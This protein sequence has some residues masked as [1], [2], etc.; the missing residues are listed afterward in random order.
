MQKLI[1][2]NIEIPLCFIQSISWSKRA[3]TITHNGGYISA[4][5]FE[6]SEISVKMRIDFGTCK[7][8]GLDPAQAFGILDDLKTDRTAMSG[9]FY[10]GG[11]PIYPELEFALTNCN[12]TEIADITGAVSF[13]ECALVFSGVKA[14]KN[15]VREKALELD[16]DTVLP[17]IRISVDGQTLTIQDSI[18]IN[19]LKTDP[20]SISLVLS[21][22]SD[23]DI[24]SRSGF[25]SA[26]AKKGIIEASL[27]QGKTVFY[28]IKADLAEEQLS[29]D[30]SIYPQQAN[31]IVTKTYQDTD[32]QDIISDLARYAGIACICIVSGHVDYYRAFKT[33]LECLRDLQASAGFIMSYRQGVLTCADVPD[34]IEGVAELRYLSLTEDSDTEPIHGCYWYDGINQ[35]SEGV[36]DNSAMQ[37]QACFRSSS[38]NWAERC[39]KFARYSKNAIVVLSDINPQIDTHSA[40]ILASNDG[41]VDCLCEWIEFDWIQNTMQ[42]ECHYVD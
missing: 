7:A 27:P 33:P 21:V 31:Q 30:G 26:L 28:V 29:L 39:L 11:Y 1:C 40:V 4:R 9:V 36:I 25:M 20:D 38:E 37:V 35:Q 6:S 18:Q 10:L 19:E 13:I 17:E 34:T 3:K 23:M 16:A 22:G 32:L 2:A 12:K 5:G 42:V 15:V 14:V 8:F 24:V 41:V